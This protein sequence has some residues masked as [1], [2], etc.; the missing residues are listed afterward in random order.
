MIPEG[1]EGRGEIQLMVD[2]ETLLHADD[3]IY[4]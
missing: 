1:L 4:D 3:N 2:R